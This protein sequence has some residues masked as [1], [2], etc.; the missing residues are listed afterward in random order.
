M[1]HT[2]NF[3]SSRTK[4][5]HTESIQPTGTE[6]TTL[7]LRPRARSSLDT[8]VIPN[9]IRFPS[10]KPD[11]TDIHITQGLLNHSEMQ[12]RDKP[13][14]IRPGPYRSSQSKSS[15]IRE[16]SSAPRP[17][18]RN[19]HLLR[20]NV[21]VRVRPAITMQ[22]PPRFGSREVIVVPHQ[23]PRKDVA[24][25]LQAFT[26]FQDQD[27]AREYDGV[28]EP[29]DTGHTP[30]RMTSMTWSTF[31]HRVLTDSTCS[32]RRS[33]ASY[34]KDEYNQLAEK[35]GLRRMAAASSGTSNRYHGSLKV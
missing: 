23:R 13:S 10:S 6:S 3:L 2:L 19:K 28:N 1:H 7:G 26:T 33:G 34:F 24:K 16:R 22:P 11:Q 21:P 18:S 9:R 14:P 12:P 32:S 4:S 8:F 25:Q 29:I 35:H 27:Q 30:S 5:G 17:G 31:S 20:P 15:P